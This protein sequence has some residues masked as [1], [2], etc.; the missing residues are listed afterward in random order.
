[1]ME[2][3][4]FGVRLKSSLPFVLDS[5]LVLKRENL[6]SE[7]ISP[8]HFYIKKPDGA[9]GS[10]LLRVRQ[11]WLVLTNRAFAVQFMK[12]HVACAPKEYAEH[13]KE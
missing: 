10:I 5:I 6:E 1:M 7:E 2:V 13:I 9:H 8:G 3:T 12:D 4:K 11:A